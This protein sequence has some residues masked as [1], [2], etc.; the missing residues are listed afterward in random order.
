MSSGIRS[1]LKRIKLSLRRYDQ[2]LTIIGALIVFLTYATREWKQAQLKDTVQSVESARATFDLLDGQQELSSRLSRLQS[3]LELSPRGIHEPLVQNQNLGR[4]EVQ[5]INLDDATED[6]VR[7]IKKL[8]DELYGNFIRLLKT[9]PNAGDL[10]QVQDVRNTML[11]GR[12]ENDAISVAFATE[13]FASNTFA[14]L[15]NDVLKHADEYTEDEQRGY[16]R[17][18]RLGAGLFVIGWIVALVPKLI[19]TGEQGNEPDYLDL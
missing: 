18:N 12:K 4:V 8:N 14:K 1:E 9:A 10:Q 6:D 5:T 19:G 17:Y 13:T 16:R 11:D 2:L 15:K 3:T 7:D